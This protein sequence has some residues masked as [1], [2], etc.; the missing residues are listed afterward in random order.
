M[1]PDDLPDVFT[2]LQDRYRSVINLYE[3][4]I[5]WGM[6]AGVL[7]YFGHPKAH[8]N[9]ADRFTRAGIGIIET[10]PSRANSGSNSP[11]KGQPVLSQ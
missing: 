5:A 1:D 4:F 3:G 10:M 9:G 11:P 8:E 2:S 7:V 6:G